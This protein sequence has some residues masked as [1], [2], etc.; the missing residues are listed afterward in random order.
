MYKTIE[1][2]EKCVCFFLC[3]KQA[4][5]KSGPE[6]LDLAENRSRQLCH[7]WAFVAPDFRAAYIIMD[8]CRCSCFVILVLGLSICLFC[9]KGGEEERS[10]RLT[11]AQSMQHVS[12][13]TYHLHTYI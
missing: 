11:G 9:V 8:M 3:K 5:S 12:C 2:V 1:L 4:P 13:S 6:A 7:C 10:K